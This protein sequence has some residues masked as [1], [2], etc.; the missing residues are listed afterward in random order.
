[1][2]VDEANTG[3]CG[4]TGFIPTIVRFDICP[5]WFRR[6]ARAKAA[7]DAEEIIWALVASSA[8]HVIGSARHPTFRGARVGDFFNDNH[9]HGM[10]GLHSGFGLR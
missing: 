6:V 1:M 5:S 7:S 8:C 4:T 10:A 9:D 3:F 2:E